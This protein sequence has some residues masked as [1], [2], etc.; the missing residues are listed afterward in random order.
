MRGVGCLLALEE[1]YLSFNG[2]KVIED[3]ERLTR[4]RVLDLG[5]NMVEKA[6]GVWD[7]THRLQCLSRVFAIGSSAAPCMRRP[8][9]PL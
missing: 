1:L 5:K 7:T 6:R 2:I 8:R 9:R 3:L 4:L